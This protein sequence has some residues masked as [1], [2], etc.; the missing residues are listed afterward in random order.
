MSLNFFKRRKVL[1]EINSL[2]LTP[3]RQMEFETKDDGK[4]DILMPRFRNEMLKR[5]LHSKRKGEYIKIHLDDL[6]SAIWKQIDGKMNVHEICS[7]LQSTHPE[8]L[9]PPEETEERVSKF[10][11]LLY[12][13]RYLTFLEI[14]K[15]KN[16]ASGK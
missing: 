14:T 8:K 9:N 1:K 11:S 13:E 6:G 2:D 16:P 5:A 7:R 3:V 12:Q 10:L 15:E 4:V